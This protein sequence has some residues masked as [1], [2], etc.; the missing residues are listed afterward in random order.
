MKVP[1]FP[2]AMSAN[3]PAQAM[4]KE[5]YMLMALGMMH[6]QGQLRKGLS[7]ADQNIVNP[8]HGNLGTRDQNVVP[9]PTVGD[10]DI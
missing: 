4:P 10:K 6:S 3:G 2:G 7:T 5:Q 1:S 8:E 9:R